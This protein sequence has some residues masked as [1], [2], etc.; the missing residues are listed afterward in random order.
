VFA[1]GGD[2]LAE[3]RDP[4]MMRP[5]RSPVNRKPHGDEKNFCPE[6]W[7]PAPAA[8]TTRAGPGKPPRCPRKPLSASPRRFR[9]MVRVWSHPDPRRVLAGC[10]AFG[11]YLDP[12][13]VLRCDGV[14]GCSA[15][16]HP[17]PLRFSA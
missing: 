15:Y 4:P 7:T 2:V 17:H 6:K 3:K 11:R 13:P 8:R 14:T 16:K 10:S 9:C 1:A 12:P 5:A